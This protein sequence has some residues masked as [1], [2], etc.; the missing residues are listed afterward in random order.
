[1]AKCNHDEGGQH[2]CEYVDARDRLIPKAVELA[3]AVGGR[4]ST[5]WSL[6]FHGHMN[7]LAKD[8]GVDRS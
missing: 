1:M 7:R 6:S 4:E 5:E 8:A 2:D 3:N